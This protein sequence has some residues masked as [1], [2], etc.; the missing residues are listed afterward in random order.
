[1]GP[2]GDATGEEE[3]AEPVVLEVAEAVAAALDLLDAEV[4]ATVAPLLARP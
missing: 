1:M 3:D 4:L 2:L